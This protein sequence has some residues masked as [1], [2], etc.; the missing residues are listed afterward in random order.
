MSVPAEDAADG[1]GEAKPAGAAGYAELAAVITMSTAIAALCWGIVASFPSLSAAL[2]V[3]AATAQVGE[4]TLE[5]L[6]ILFDARF[7]ISGVVL[8]LGASAGV[9]GAMSST[10]IAS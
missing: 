7:L 8:A 2:L 5:H 10:H 3:N 9:P 4:A 6:S 1:E